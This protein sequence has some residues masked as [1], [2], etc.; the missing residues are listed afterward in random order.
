M[1]WYKFW[2]RIR[3]TRKTVAVLAES[4]SSAKVVT[5]INIDFQEIGTLERSHDKEEIS[6]SV[7]EDPMKASRRYKDL[8]K[9]A[10]DLEE[11]ISEINKELSRI[12][13]GMTRFRPTDKKFAEFG[14]SLWRFNEDSWGAVYEGEI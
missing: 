9:K 12:S 13:D 1:N 4:E 10:K 7:L 3:N 5:K 6:F 8:L 2:I 14:G 11:Q